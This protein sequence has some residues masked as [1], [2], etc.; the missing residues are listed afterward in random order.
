[1]GILDEQFRNK[2][3]GLDIIHN[4]N[5]TSMITSMIGKQI[6]EFTDKH[7]KEIEDKAED[8]HPICGKAV[9]TFNNLNDTMENAIDSI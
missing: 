2:L 9:R 8:I 7:R 3:R 5:P 1:M 4:S 6:K